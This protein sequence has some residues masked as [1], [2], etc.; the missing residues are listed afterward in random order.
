MEKNKKTREH[1]GCGDY[2]HSSVVGLYVSWYYNIVVTATAI[3]AITNKPFKTE[4]LFIINNG[5]YVNVSCLVPAEHVDSISVVFEWSQLSSQHLQSFQ[6]F[7]ILQILQ[8]LL[9]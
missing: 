2:L 9:L 8:I 4:K 6:N 3:L 5:K 7:P 1:S